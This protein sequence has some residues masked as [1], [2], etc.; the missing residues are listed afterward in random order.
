MGAFFADYNNP[1]MDVTCR[2]CEEQ[3][4]TEDASHLWSTWEA[5][6]HIRSIV[7]EWPKANHESDAH[8]ESTLRTSLAALSSGTVQTGPELESPFE[9]VPSQLSR[10]LTDPTLVKLLEHPGQ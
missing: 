4:T 9:W 10:F 8:I 2:A 1:Y 5:L 3:G 6:R 7:H